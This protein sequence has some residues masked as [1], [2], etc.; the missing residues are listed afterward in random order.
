MDLAGARARREIM[1]P[2]VISK[3]DFFAKIRAAARKVGMISPQVYEWDRKLISSYFTDGCLREAKYILSDRKMEND[4][5]KDIGY[6]NGK[7]HEGL[8]T[9]RSFEIN[10]WIF[11]DVAYQRFQRELER[12]GLKPSAYHPLGTISPVEGEAERWEKRTP[13]YK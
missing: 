2:P 8:F 3:R 11:S 5:D 12:N 7:N 6:L 4:R 10:E 9:V 1:S 13:L